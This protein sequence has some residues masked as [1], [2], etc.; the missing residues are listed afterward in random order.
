MIIRYQQ[1][2]VAPSPPP[3]HPPP[4]SCHDR[5]Q[6]LRHMDNS[7]ST[8]APSSSCAVA[9]D[10]SLNNQ[11]RRSSK[12]DCMCVL[13]ICTRAGELYLRFTHIDPTDPQRP[14]GFGV[15]VTGADDSYT[16]V[17]FT[18]IRPYSMSACAAS[19]RMPV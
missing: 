19:P 12:P 9:L 13:H 10:V 6:Y 8:A 7:A 11:I 1:L 2:P 3:P 4:H 18:V 17:P 14:F 16:G 5:Q 15:K